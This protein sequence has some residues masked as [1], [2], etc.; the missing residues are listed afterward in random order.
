MGFSMNLLSAC[1][2]HCW[3][4]IPL[5]NEFMNS[6]DLTNMELLKWIPV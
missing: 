5:K 6:R 3:N 2:F 1:I 4:K